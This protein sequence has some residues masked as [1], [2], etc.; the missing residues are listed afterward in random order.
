MKV[1][2]IP[3]G[4]FLFGGVLGVALAVPLLS[5][6]IFAL[7]QK[8]GF[9]PLVAPLDEIFWISLV[10]SGLPAFVAGGGVARTVA[11]RGAERADMTLGRA[12]GLGA[13]TMAVGGV[14]LALLAAVP[15]GALPDD[16]RHWAPV[17]V[18]GLA[19]GAVTGLALSLLVALRQ[20]RHVT[21]VA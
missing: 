21:R 3:R 20:R 9:G 5:L 15:L 4:T 17:G 18:V 7:T 14:G 2:K 6:G 13:A 1:R 19:A 16:P 8:L 11:H 12:L 10:F